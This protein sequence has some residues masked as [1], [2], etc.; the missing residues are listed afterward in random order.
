MNLK[1]FILALSTIAAGLVELIVGGILPTIAADFNISLGTAGQL[2]TVFA[3]IYAIAGPVLLVLTSKIERKKLYL[4]SLFAF[5]LG[6][7]MIYFSPNFTFMMVARVLTAISTALIVVLSLT[8]AVKI[9]APTQ[10]A[11]ALGLIYMGISSS[12]VLGVPLGILISNAFGWRVI[13]L[14]IAVLSVGSIVL[15]TLFLER[16]PG[17]NTIPLSQQLKAVGS[18][19][20]GSAHLATIFMLAGH[21]TIYAYFTPF[22]ETNLHLNSYWISI[23][24]L[25]FG[26]AAVSGGAF[27]GILSD[28]IGARKS[29]IIVISAFAIVLFLLPLS[30]FSLVLF[31]P[32]MMVWGALS[33]SL[34]PPQQSY[35]IQTDPA[36]SDIQQ[37]FNNSAVQIGISLGSAIGGIVLNQT[38]TISSTA[39]VGSIIAIISLLCAIFSLTRPTMIRENTSFQSSEI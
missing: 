24:Y 7:I 8:I 34:A 12:L 26:I 14:G 1:V 17:G 15:I 13:F 11:K 33:W 37:S 5:F 19:K 4:A 21:Y 39:W 23:C 25:I 28:W 6:N 9:V 38:G 31:I 30:T 27:G 20:I 32:V 16:I 22:L 36:T 29:I 3:L 18:A 2:I 35:L 10:Q